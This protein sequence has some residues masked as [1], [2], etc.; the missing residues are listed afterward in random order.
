M[1]RVSGR[2][3]SGLESPSGLELPPNILLNSGELGSPEQRK[4]E[5]CPSDPTATLNHLH[6]QTPCL[7]G[8]WPPPQRIELR[9]GWPLP[10]GSRTPVGV[11]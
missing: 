1:V 3:A 4:K 5:A 2:L 9:L 8:S 6:R 7:S 10:Y 11:L